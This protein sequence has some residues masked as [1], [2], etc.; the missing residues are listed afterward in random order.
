MC[1]NIMRHLQMVVDRRRLVLVDDAEMA[2]APMHVWQAV[3]V[4]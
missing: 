3:A 1:K 4:A 2:E